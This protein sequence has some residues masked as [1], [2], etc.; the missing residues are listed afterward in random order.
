M[1]RARSLY[2]S[3]TSQTSRVLPIPG[4]P[5]IETMAPRPSS[6]ASIV[7]SRTV[8][9]KSRPTS[10]WLGGTGSASSGRVTLKVGSGSRMPFRSCEPISSSSKPDSTWRF[11]AG[12]MTTPP[13]P[14]ISCRRE[15]T[16]TVS[17][18]AFQGS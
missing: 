18:R 17:P 11:V 1:K 4:S 13:S 14:A 7:R 15:A 6:S 9:S 8:S 2:R 5:I 10:G 16:L 12:P 3:R